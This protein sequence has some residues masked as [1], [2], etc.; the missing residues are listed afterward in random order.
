[1]LVVKPEYQTPKCQ[2][3]QR[4]DVILL[5]AME[6]NNGQ[7]HSFTKSYSSFLAMQCSSNDILQRPST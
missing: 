2:V 6:E 4:Q 5:K 1:M 7:L 3:R